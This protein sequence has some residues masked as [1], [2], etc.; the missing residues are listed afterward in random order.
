MSFSVKSPIFLAGAGWS[1]APS[2]TQEL[3]K[4]AN[5]ATATKSKKIRRFFI[6]GL[7]SS[8]YPRDRG[9]IRRPQVTSSQARHSNHNQTPRKKHTQFTPAT[10]AQPPQK[11]VTVPAR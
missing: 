7:L 11:V 8:R 5:A 3:Y 9:S 6:K 2:G 4:M 1:A 10:A